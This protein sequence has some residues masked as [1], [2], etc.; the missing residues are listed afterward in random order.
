MPKP[1]TPA[2]KTTTRKPVTRKSSSVKPT[3]A[4]RKLVATKAKYTAEYA[5]YLARYELDG[6]GRPRL[7]PGE[8]DRLD[9]ELLELLDL[10]SEGGLDDEQII[11]IRE[12]EY[13]LLESE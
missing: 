5:D 4:P 11:R 1:K 9:D 6:E 7:S 12:L 8:F 13:L 10:E 3:A 2:K